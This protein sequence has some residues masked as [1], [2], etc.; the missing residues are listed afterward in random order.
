MG[1]NAFN[2]LPS[3]SGSFLTIA[4]LP[5]WV[6]EEESRKKRVYPFLPGIKDVSSE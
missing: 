2:Q 4:F 3:F 6:D 1:F 5:T